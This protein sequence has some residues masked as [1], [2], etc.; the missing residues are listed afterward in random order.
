MISRQQTAWQIAL[1]LWDEVKDLEAAGIEVI[2]VDEPGLKESLPLR[3][4][5]AGASGLGRQRVQA[6]H[7]CGG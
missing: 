3:G 6:R 2:Q 4:G 5:L 1:A 7:R